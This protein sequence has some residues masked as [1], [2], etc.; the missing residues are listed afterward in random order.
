MRSQ[1]ERIHTGEWT[2]KTGRILRN[3]RRQGPRWLAQVMVQYT[4]DPFVELR[5]D[6][7]MGIDLG[8]TT[9]AALHVRVAGVPQKWAVL[10]GDGRAMLA[11]RS[12]IRTQIVRLL[13]GLRSRTTLL[14]GPARQ[15]ALDKLRDLRKQEQRVM[16]TGARKI[17]ARIADY[18][19]RNGAGVWQM[20]AL[21]DD[22]KGESPW[23]RRNWAPGMLLD[24]VRWQAAQ[25]GAEIRMVDPAYTS[26]RCS[27]CGH[28]D[29]ANRPKGARK[30]SFF[31]CVKCGRD[32]H[33]D[34][35]AA[36]NLS[37]ENISRLIAEARAEL[38]LD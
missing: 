7:V 17:A 3:P 20:E 33:A 15:A 21:G 18:A 34:K 9:P 10:A 5:K 25:L 11:S 16:K 12:V 35:N 4:P 22:I 27:E 32:D 8:V 38:K 37:D 30:A 24:A 13:R 26:Q 31:L 23:L 19:R 1:L 6:A 28:I 29:R 36:R 2:L 14:H